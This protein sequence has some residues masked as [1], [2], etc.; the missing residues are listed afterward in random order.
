MSAE[1]TYGEAKIGTALPLLQSDFEPLKVRPDKPGYKTTEFY[2]T[3]ATQ[4]IGVLVLFG[5]LGPEVK[6][7]ANQY[8]SDIVVHATALVAVLGSA[9]KY[10]D[11]RS[12]T[13]QG[14]PVTI[15]E[16]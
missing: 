11:G 6:D 12:K 4:A 5:V 2:V 8:L 16:S 14:G 13:K 3:V 7:V 9:W 10:I 1:R 15:V